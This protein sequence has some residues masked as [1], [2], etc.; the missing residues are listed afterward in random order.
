MRIWTARGL[1]IWKRGA[2]QAAKWGAACDVR[3]TP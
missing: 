2:M 3:G 1:V